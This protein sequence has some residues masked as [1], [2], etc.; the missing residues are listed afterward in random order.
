MHIID[1]RQIAKCVQEIISNV[2][3]KGPEF[4]KFVAENWNIIQEFIEL[5]I[6]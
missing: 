5:T 4:K 2:A 6:K 3:L 1:Y